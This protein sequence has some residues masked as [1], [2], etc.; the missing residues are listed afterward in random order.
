MMKVSRS[1]YVMKNVSVAL[2]M[3]VIKNLLGFLS[4]TVFVYILGAEYL[5]VNSLFSDILTVLSFAELGIGNAMVFSLYKPISQDNT[6]KIKS[7]MKLYAKTYKIIGFVIAVLGICLVPFIGYIVGDVSYVKEN[8]VVLYILF[9][10]NSVISYFFVYKKSLIIADQKNYIVDI[11]QQVFYA[12]QVV[13]QIAFLVI[14]K[15]FITYLILMVVT[16]FL[17]NYFVAKKADKMYPYLKDKEVEPLKK[18]EINDIVTNVKALVVYKI[19]GIILESTD[20]IFVSSLINVI[21]VGLYANYKMIVNVFRTIGNQ[22]MNSIVASVG[23]LNAGND[24]KKK[25]IVFDEMFYISG[26]FYGF[27]TAGLCC[28]LS[29]LISVWLGDKYVIGFD[30]V[31]AACTYFYI[32]NMHYPCYTY[33]T[34]AGLF[35][36]G[37]YIPMISAAINIVLDIIMGK[38]WGL[39]GILWASTIARVVTYEIID[40]VI[41]YRRVFKR[42]VMKYFVQ[43]TAITGLIIVDTLISYMFA[44]SVCKSSG[45]FGLL[46]KIVLFSVFYNICYLL[47]TFRTPQFKSLLNIGKVVLHKMSAKKSR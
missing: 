31:L 16:T 36:F 8:V 27:A 14:T 5:G 37:K 29:P 20:S 22:V 19:G 7:L 38:V 3:Q 12:I 44:F 4:R 34:T 11:Y 30:S 6:E 21:T 10:L 33:R 13:L 17:N 40:P 2:V 43:Y 41:V 18:D 42:S 23:N 1:E 28:F 39:A 45:V 15:Q 35:V 24:V 9:L 32:S 25:E 47:V 46:I 26:W